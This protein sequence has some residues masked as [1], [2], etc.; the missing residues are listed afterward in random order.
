MLC[1]FCISSLCFVLMLES[2][3]RPNL[4]T[5]QK[6]KKKKSNL[7]LM[8]MYLV[9]VGRKISITTGSD[10]RQSQTQGGGAICCEQLGG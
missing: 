2:T 9:K 6:K 7:N 8:S 3:F 5:G 4:L 10:L 1:E